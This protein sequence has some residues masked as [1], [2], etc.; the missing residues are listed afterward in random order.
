DSEIG[1]ATRDLLLEAAWFD[2]VSVRRASRALALR[3]EA[4]TRFE[5]GADPEMAE[6]AS[7]RCAELIQ[8]IAGGEILSGVV[9]A[10]PG[11]RP[12]ES[13][14]LARREF[15]R[16]MGA[17]VPDAEIEA[18]L[19]TLGFAPSRQDKNGANSPGA[20][21]KCMQP[22]WRSDVSREIDL[23]EEIARHHG[24]DKFAPRL[25]A[26]KTPAARMPHAAEL[27]A[28]R[29]RL[30]GLGYREALTIP[31]VDPELDAA[32]RAP[33]DIPVS[34]ANPLSQDASVMRTSGI[35]SML[36]ALEWNINRG[37]RNLRLFEIGRAYRWNG[38]APEERPILTLG[39]SGMAREKGPFESAREFSF[40]D[41]K[42][43][44]D[45]I[46]ELAGGFIWNT[47]APAWLHPARSA[48][49]I[50]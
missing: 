26:A 20:V 4:S 13:L 8:Q 12:A 14:L 38:N 49:F 6:L 1:F 36:G 3:T 17:D 41:L 24:L 30:L 22:S 44:L 21:W 45:L 33:G 42:G 50:P 28:L 11:K 18:I 23:V 16:V 46:G 32:F 39:A 43:D 5:R 29:E 47:S 35:A 25:P 37:Q 10:Y 27:A 48:G 2:P 19:S 9:D 7:R 31:L 15:L 34:L 40:A